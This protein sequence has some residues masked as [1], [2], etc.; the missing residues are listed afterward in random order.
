MISMAR[1]LGI[2]ITIFGG[3]PISTNMRSTIEEASIFGTYSPRVG[4]IYFR[5][6][7]CSK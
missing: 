1:N 6:L 7:L 2:D 5:L 4:G 3:Q